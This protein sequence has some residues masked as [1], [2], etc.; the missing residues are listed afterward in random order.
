MVLKSTKYDQDQKSMPAGDD[1]RSDSLIRRVSDIKV[2]YG[3]E[4]RC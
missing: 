3:Q 1:L 4:N 2:S